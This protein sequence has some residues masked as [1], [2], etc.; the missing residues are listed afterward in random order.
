MAVG[1]QFEPVDRLH[2]GLEQREVRPL[3]T[4]ADRVL[5]RAAGRQRGQ[6]VLRPR[7]ELELRPVRGRGQPVGLPIPPIADIWTGEPRKKQEELK[8]KYATMPVRNFQAYVDGSEKTKGSL[9]PP[10]AQQV[11]AILDSVVQ[12]VLTNKD[13]DHAAL[14]KD[15]ETKVNAVLAQVK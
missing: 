8:G 3:A 15:A 4:R 9:E 11:Y 5:E 10:Q 7:R 6:V 12:A 14:L 13:A 2:R 1:V